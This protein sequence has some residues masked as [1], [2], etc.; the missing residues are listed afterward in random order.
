MRVHPLL[1]HVA[2]AY[3]GP[4]PPEPDDIVD[5]VL[6]LEELD[7]F[8]RERSEVPRREEEVYSA[9]IRPG[10]EL[11]RALFDQHPCVPGEVRS[12]LAA[13]LA[14]SRALDVDDLAGDPPLADL[15]LWPTSAAF[16]ARDADWYQFRRRS[17]RVCGVTEAS[18]P[19][20]A[21]RLFPNL[22]LSSAFPAC[23]GT[24]EGG[25]DHV[26][27]SVVRALT[28]LNDDLLPALGDYAI[29]EGLRRFTAATGFETTME[30]NAERNPDLTFSFPHKDGS[31]R[32]V[33]APH[34]KLSS[35]DVPGDGR[36]YF[37]RVYFNPR[38]EDGARP[39]IHV[40]H[41]GGH[42]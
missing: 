41:V 2:N 40:G 26:L 1:V 24:L 39:R 22:V 13:V 18:F 8:V 19:E 34:M 17:L 7:R 42:L 9:E 25:F 12:I 36:H 30:G 4:T 32:I 21:S 37:N 6:E 31:T 15:G 14:R 33:C 20:Q 11:W 16:L 3:R 5:R 28:A 35:S 27:P 29:V 10:V 38:Q 23:L